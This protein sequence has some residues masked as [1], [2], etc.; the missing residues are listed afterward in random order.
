MGKSGLG[1]QVWKEMLQARDLIE[2]QILWKTR[3]ENFNR[4]FDNWTTYGCLYNI[5]KNCRDWDDR[6]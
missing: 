2:H 6:Y 3:K 4:W 1:S 5:V